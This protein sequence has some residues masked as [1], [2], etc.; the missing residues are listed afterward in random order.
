MRGSTWLARGGARS[1]RGA[2]AG[3]SRPRRRAGILQSIHQAEKK[4]CGAGQ[5]RS[6][7]DNAAGM[8]LESLRCHRAGCTRSSCLTST[9]ALLA[10]VGRVAF[11]AVEPVEELAQHE[12]RAVA[13][14]V[15][16]HHLG[17]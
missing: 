2:T 9:E 5:A 12:V 6:P 17:G 3:A 4:K 10:E 15:H 1:Q 7:R 16:V 11:L 13:R 8:L 14:H